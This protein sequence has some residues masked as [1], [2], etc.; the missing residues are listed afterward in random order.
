MGKYVARD[1]ARFKGF[2]GPVNIPWGSVLDEQDGLLF[3]MEKLSA[4]SQ[5]KMPMTSSLLIMTVKGNFAG[6]W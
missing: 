3:G 1:R 6:N 5:A 2:S 4:P